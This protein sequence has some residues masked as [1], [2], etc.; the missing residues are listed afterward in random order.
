MA[1]SIRI[2]AQYDKM[3]KDLCMS[4]IN[5]QVF[6]TYK[7]MLLFAAALGNHHDSRIT[8]TKSALDPVRL[9][10]FRGDYDLELLNCIA[11]VDTKEPRILNPNEEDEKIKILE[12]YINGGLDI[13]FNQIYNKAG[14]WEDHLIDLIVSQDGEA[15]DPLDDIT[16]A[17]E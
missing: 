12:E 11:L 1:D 17:W 2:P 6:E 4:K 13:I 7:D 15:S 10:Y 16:K 3:F 14:S 9:S 8:F 5:Q